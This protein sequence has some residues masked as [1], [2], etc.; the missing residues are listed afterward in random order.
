MRVSAI[1]ILATLLAACSAE[2][3][4]PSTPSEVAGGT[5]FVA[6]KREGSISRIDLSSGTET[7]RAET[8]EN[9]HE[10]T[11]S[12]DEAYVM[13]ACYSGRTLEIYATPHLRPAGEI[14]L[15]ENA[16]VHSAL[17]LEDG[18]VLAGAEGRGSLYVVARALRDGVVPPIISLQ[19]FAGDGE[20][21][22]LLAVSPDRQTAW[23]TIIDEGAVVRYDLESGTEAARRVVGNQI[24]AIAL[25]PD[26]S[27]LWV[28]SNVDGKAYRLDPETLEIEAEV[29]VGEVPIRLAAHPSGDFVVT[30]NL[31]DGSLSVIDSRGAELVRTISVSGSREAGQVTLVFSVNGERLYAAETSA[32]MIAEVD[33]ASGEVLRRLPTGEGGDG[34]AVVNSER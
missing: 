32:D 12:P 8:C 9:P 28:A 25:T 26:G 31:G 33:F 13:L 29:A 10:L 22:H 18:R 6:N 11:V 15:G 5:M 2:A 20:G 19:E 21:P 17:W 7:H 34:L 23:G 3:Q 24:E 30:S 14:M 16:R 27:G 1:A 4:A